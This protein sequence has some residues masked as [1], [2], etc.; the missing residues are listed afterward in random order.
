MSVA[1]A[2]GAKPAVGGARRW[3]A[4]AALLVA[5][6][7]VGMTETRFPSIV[8][9]VHPSVDLIRLAT[10]LFSLVVALAVGNTF[11]RLPWRQPSV[12]IALAFLGCLLA[13]WLGGVSWPSSAD[14]S[15]YIYH[16]DTFAAGRLWN[17]APA[18]PSLFEQYRLLIKDGRMLSAYPPGWAAI[19]LPF[20]LFRMTWLTNPL[21][22]VALGVALEGACRQLGLSEAV[23]R[24]VL[25]LVLLTPFTLFLGG[26][27]FPQTLACALV[28][29]V[30]WAQLADESFPSRWRK[31]LIGALFGIMLLARPDVFAVVIFIFGI[32]RLGARRLGAIADGMWV[33]GGL[34]PF[35]IGF[36]VYNAAITGNPLQLPSTW[37]GPGL[38]DY[39]EGVGDTELVR[40]LSRD[41]YYLGGLAQFGGLPVAGL[42]LLALAFKVRRGNFRFY[43]FF[44]PAAVIFFSIIPFAGGHQYGPRYWFWAWPFAALTVA[45]AMV[46]ASGHLHLPGRTVSL[47]RFAAATLVFAAG[48][49]CVLLVTTNDYIATQREVFR[50]SRPEAP[51]VVLLPTRKLVLW[52]WQSHKVTMY[53]LDFTR[54]DL[55]LKGPI[56]YG[57]ADVPDAVARS[58]RLKG[59]EV[60]RWEP[61]GRLVREVC[62]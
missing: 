10:G 57:R 36:G 14:E 3:L 60:Y 23:R 40:S 39:S 4:A 43:D 20:S 5:G 13:G 8:G 31:L 59:R 53:S 50:F 27:L 45:T 28:A 61:P 58:C 26:S 2:E 12:A 29:S 32:D 21:L 52:P 49:F 47:D 16:A 25:A 18:D 54:N 55:D 62:P 34:L 15:A 1:V 41:V 11:W 35:V 17:P 44:L 24:P 9:D 37:G 38:F 46:D 42:G 19:L 56:L 6:V 51:A 48:A 33:V 22:T 7:T 30:V